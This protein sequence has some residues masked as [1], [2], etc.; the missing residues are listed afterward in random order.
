[1]SL[2]ISLA[3]KQANQQTPYSLAV[4]QGVLR[5]GQSEWLLCGC[6][7]EFL[8]RPV[9]LHV[10][11]VRFLTPGITMAPAFWVVTA[12]SSSLWQIYTLLLIF[13]FACRFTHIWK[14]LAEDA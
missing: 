3:S 14:E 1:M 4:T 9:L 5:T 13:E 11:V 12:W 10:W 6:L 2:Q 8:I 7:A